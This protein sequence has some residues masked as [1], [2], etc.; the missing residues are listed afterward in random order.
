MRV[1]AVDR[2]QPPKPDFVESLWSMDRLNDL[3]EMS[4]VVFIACGLMSALGDPT[5][6]E[7]LILKRQQ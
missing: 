1:V 4:D 3:L 2:H 6:Q 7:S 5:P